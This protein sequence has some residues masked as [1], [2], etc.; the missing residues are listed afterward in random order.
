MKY[1]INGMGRALP[2]GA[3]KANCPFGGSDDHYSSVAEAQRAYEDH[4]SQE[5]AKALNGISKPRF[6]KEN[7]EQD[8]NGREIY[9]E[10][11]FSDSQEQEDLIRDCII[12]KRDMSQLELA[13][14]TRYVEKT[15]DQLVSNKKTTEKTHA[16]Y[17]SGGLVFKPERLAAHTEIIDE[18]FKQAETVPRNGEA[19]FA[20]GLG[21]AGKSTVLANFADVDE[22]KYFT[23]NPDNIKEIMAEKGLI[24]KVDG[25]TPMEASPLVHEE[26]SH[27]TKVL[28]EKLR[29]QGTNLIFD[30][31]MSSEGSVRNRSDLV[32]QAGY[33]KIEAVFV[34]IEPK[35]SLER[36]TYRYNLGLSQYLTRAK[37]DG[38]RYL[39]KY[40]VNDQTPADPNAFRSRNAETLVELERTGCFTSTPR[41]F[42][43]NTNGSDPKELDYSEFKKY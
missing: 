28:F 8:S 14:H 21:G 9:Y 35:T 22:A 42:D 2:C 37:G 26:A 18:L 40:L 24:P 39:P 23:L 29:K 5:M 43:N 30:I 7:S 11:P 20:G 32:K 16:D 41:V 19:I 4:M 6:T 34:D 1:H 10:A 31:V 15:L 36:G 3:V 12:N 13:R 38:G 25:L 27:I 17:V 33:T